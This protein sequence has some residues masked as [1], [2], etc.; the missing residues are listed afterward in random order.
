MV[1]VFARAGKKRGLSSKFEMPES[2]ILP[3]WGHSRG[4]VDA[5]HH[6]MDENHAGKREK[7][8]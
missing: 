7:K 3:S 4:R 6:S 1:P 2:V 5:S 8:G